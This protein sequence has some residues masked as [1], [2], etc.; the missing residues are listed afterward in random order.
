MNKHAWRIISHFKNF[1]MAS[2]ILII[3]CLVSLFPLLLTSYVLYHNSSSALQEELGDYTV[4][5]TRQVNNRLELFQEEMMRLVNIIRFD[6]DVQKFLLFSGVND[7]LKS[8]ETTNEISKMLNAIGSLRGNLYGIYIR[9]DDGVTAYGA[10]NSSARLNYHFEKES[11]FQEMSNVDGFHLRPTQ[12]EYYADNRPV[13]TFA[14]RLVEFDQYWERGTLLIDFDPKVIEQM[15][16]PI[17]LGETG[18]VFVMTANGIPINQAGKFP[19]G[20]MN[21]QQFE[22][23]FQQ[24]EGHFLTKEKDKKILVGYY[25]APST[26]WK[27]VGVVPFDEVAVK[28][29]R[30]RF[31][32]FLIVLTSVL[33]II[34]ISILFSKGITRPLKKLETHMKAVQRGNFTVQLQNDRKDEIGKLSHRYNHMINELKRMED[35]V[36]RSQIREFKLELL[37]RDS[38][39]NAL[40][41][42]INPHFLYNTLNT[43][44]CIGEV[45]NVHQI[46]LVSKSLANM[47]EYSIGSTK[48]A[49]LEEELNHVDAYMKIIQVRFPNRITC[50]KE[51]QPD[52]LGETII[53]L[54]IQ[55]IVENAVIHGLEKK[56][57][58]GNIWIR[59][60]VEG[61]NMHIFVR[62]DGLGMDK[63][64]LESVR[65]NLDQTTEAQT[66]EG[67][68]HMGLMNVQ[69]RLLLHYGEDA[70]FLIDSSLGEGTL[71]QFI[72]PLKKLEG[73]GTHS[74]V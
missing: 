48:Y 56:R 34:I 43:I 32:V 68:E 21:Q 37:R 61:D 36:Y 49:A 54:I 57:G 4:E 24:E 73:G 6:E 60:F 53:K 66:G 47:F 18:Y 11:L 71:V 35:E 29:H 39:L 45:Y 15:S 65:K 70:Q 44:T 27:I 63:E 1:S 9:N 23:V 58:K 33:L 7:D 52:V 42:Q 46:S 64:K 30:I 74:D 72:L 22:E 67:R 50:H 26:G 31:I 20:L 19:K 40:Q 28:I 5:I 8:I 41:A 25:T 62:D 3:L 2:K 59:I 51:L 14:G 69:Q 38:E 12:P 55:P 10:L 16:D 13:V 17:Q